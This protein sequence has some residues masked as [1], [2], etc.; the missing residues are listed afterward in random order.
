MSKGKQRHI[1]WS[2]KYLFIT[3]SLRYSE[4]GLDPLRATTK[5]WYI[6]LLWWIFQSTTVCY[7]HKSIT[8]CINRSYHFHYFANSLEHFQ[9]DDPEVKLYIDTEKQLQYSKELGWNWHK[10]WNL[11]NISVRLEV[12]TNIT[13]SLSQLTSQ[14][15]RN[16][17]PSSL[18]FLLKTYM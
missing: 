15:L 8:N 14:R 5:N 4:V 17:L 16:H 18:S 10:S 9:G 12:T 2:S 11:P 13:N 1:F 7:P 3:I 6:K